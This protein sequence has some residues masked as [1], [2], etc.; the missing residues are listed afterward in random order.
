MF[1]F[2]RMF[3]NYYHTH[4]KRPQPPKYDLLFFYRAALNWGLKVFRYWPHFLLWFEVLDGEG[5]EFSDVVV[6]W[7]FIPVKTTLVLL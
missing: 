5:K 4:T 3:L 2:G 1:H 6:L 7:Q